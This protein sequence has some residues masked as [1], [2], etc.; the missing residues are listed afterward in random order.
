M[1]NESIYERIGA[2][3]AKVSA[4]HSRVDKIEI[5][6]RTDLEDLKKD[7]KAVVAWMNRS[8]GWAAACLFTGGIIGALIMK[9]LK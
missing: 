1:A 8:L 4:A 7:L 3:D 2:I 9:L 6:I 5:Q